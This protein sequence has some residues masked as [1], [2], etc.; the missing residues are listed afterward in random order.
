MPVNILAIDTVSEQCSV[1]L[2]RG[3]A[4]FSRSDHAP[5]LHAELV[6]PWIEALLAEAQIDLQDIDLLAVDVGPGSFTGVRIGISLAQGLSTG[7]DIPIAPVSSLQALAMQSLADVVDGQTLLVAMDARMSEVYAAGF[8]REGDQLACIR[9]PLLC[10]PES[11]DD[12]ADWQILVGSAFLVYADPLA[13]LISSAALC[14][15]D[16]S[17]NASDIALLAAQLTEAHHVRAG[18]IEPIYLRNNVAK[19]PALPT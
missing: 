17:P 13:T 12:G 10:A 2:Q 16:R 18:S 7:L 4:S 15:P 8:R 9:P 19:K 11:L 14:D 5:R 1:C 3:E 6:L